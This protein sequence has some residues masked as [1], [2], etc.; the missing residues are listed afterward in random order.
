VDNFGSVQIWKKGYSTRCQLCTTLVKAIATVAAGIGCKF[1][2]EKITRCSSAG[3]IMAD[4]LSKANFN[5]FRRTA[6]NDGWPLCV[7]PARVP[8]S[9]LAWIAQPAVD[10]DLGHRILKELAL[11]SPVLGY[12]C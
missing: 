2:I 5:D 9:I 6:L 1:T 7:E 12:N 11:C 4:A 8:A 3:P 10:D